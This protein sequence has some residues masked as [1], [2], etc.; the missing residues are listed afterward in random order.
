MQECSLLFRSRQSIRG[1]SADRAVLAPD[2]MLGLFTSNFQI[3]VVFIKDSNS[4]STWAAFRCYITDY[5]VA[6]LSCCIA[7]SEAA[8]S[9]IVLFTVFK[10]SRHML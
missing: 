8:F 4:W 9:D 7:E 5:V 6:L 10:Y 1:G 3:D 2:V